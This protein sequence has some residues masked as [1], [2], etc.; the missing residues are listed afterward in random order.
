M[1]VGENFLDKNPD[2]DHYVCAPQVQDILIKKI[3]RFE[4]TDDISLMTQGDIALLRLA[5]PIKFHG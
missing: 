1:R 3:I 5:T 2:C 4:K